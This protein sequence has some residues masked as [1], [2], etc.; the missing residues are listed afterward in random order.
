M[1][2]KAAS[3]AKGSGTPNTELVGKVTQEQLKEIAKVKMTDLNATTVE[4]AMRM[5]AGTAM[6]MGLAV[7]D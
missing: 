4:A 1:L 3:I 7:K 2:K 5:I 6:S